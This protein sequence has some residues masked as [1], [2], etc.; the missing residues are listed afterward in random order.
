MVKPE[1]M[2]QFIE[3]PWFSEGWRSL[4]LDSDDL[5]ALQEA[6]MRGPKRPPVIPGTGRLR[7]IR[8]APPSWHVGKSGACRVCY[9]YFE[10]SGVV[11]L[12]VV[13]S[14]NDKDTLNGAEKAAIR[15]VIA[16]HEVE[17]SKRPGKWR[18]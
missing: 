5:L 16:R 2:L 7:K 18:S 4:R 14:K 1:K 13:Y 11:L 12:V 6:I 15:S 10:E 17:F 9:A 8:F 3:L